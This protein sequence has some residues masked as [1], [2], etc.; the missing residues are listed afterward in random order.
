MIVD[1][2]EIE[3]MRAQANAPAD[4]AP[5]EPC[6]AAQQAGPLAPAAR[7][8]VGAPSKLARVLR[9]RV[10]VI[11][12]LATRRMPISNVRRLSL[13]MIIEFHKDVDDPLNLLINN[14]TVGRG[15][16]VKVNDHFG[17]R[18]IEIRDAATRIKSM[19]K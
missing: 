8:I 2:E 10:P 19:A 1:Q 5:T 9:I 3:A 6:D 12:Q 15:D 11:V 16:A 4:E 17:L 7:P 13:G 18:V 14:H